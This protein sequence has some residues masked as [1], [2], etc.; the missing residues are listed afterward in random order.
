MVLLCGSSLSRI[1]TEEQTPSWVCSQVAEGTSA[2]IPSTKASILAKPEQLRRRVIAHPLTAPQG[3]IAVHMAM[4]GRAE[5][6]WGKN[7]TRH[8]SSF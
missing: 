8:T 3:D 2:H 7:M 5:G 1:H 6:N 4:G